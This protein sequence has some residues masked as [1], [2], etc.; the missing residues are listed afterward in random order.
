[1]VCVARSNGCPLVAV[2]R[3]ALATRPPG[4][5]NHGAGVAAVP[6]HQLLAALSGLHRRMAKLAAAEHFYSGWNGLDSGPDVVAHR[7]PNGVE[8]VATARACGDRGRD[9]GERLCARP[10]CRR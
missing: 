6:G 3:P 10:A 5:V 2:P 1:M 9:G 4:G 7:V 8:R